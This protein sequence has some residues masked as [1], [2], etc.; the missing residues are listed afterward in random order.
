MKTD[1]AIKFYGTRKK[2]G[3]A[4]RFP[5]NKSTVRKW[6][7]LGHLPYGRALELEKETKGKLK[8]DYSC[9]PTEQQQAA[10]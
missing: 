7:I 8:V 5:V 9:Y 2:L 3:N 6:V 4:F 10:A 1:T